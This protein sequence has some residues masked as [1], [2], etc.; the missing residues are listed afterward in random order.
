MNMLDKLKKFYE[1]LSGKQKRGIVSLALVLA[2][3][4]LLLAL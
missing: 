3:S 1:S 2:L 4:A